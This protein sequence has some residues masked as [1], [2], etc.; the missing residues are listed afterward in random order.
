MEKLPGFVCNLPLLQT[1]AY[2]AHLF[3]II[4]VA[5]EI[6]T[7]SDEHKKFTLVVLDKQKEHGKRVMDQE[8]IDQFVHDLN[9]RAKNNSNALT[10]INDIIAEA[11]TMKLFETF[12]EVVP[13]TVLQL[14]IVML[15]TEEMSTIQIATL[16]KGFLLFLYGTMKNYLGPTKVSTYLP[17]YMHTYSINHLISLYI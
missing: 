16:V 1:F 15:Q 2:L 3:K 6:D 10:A 7:I 14:Y 17:T 11:Q 8:K 4:D 9:E 5:N 13:Q 12:L